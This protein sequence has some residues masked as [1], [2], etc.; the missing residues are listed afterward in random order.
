MK[1]RMR[2]PTLLILCL[3]LMMTLHLLLPLHSLLSWPLNLAGLL[4]VGAGFVLASSHA[5]LFRR[6]G[7]NIDTFGEPG[8]LVTTGCFARSRN[9]MYLGMVI[10]LGGVALLLGSL[11][12]WIGPVVFGVLV[13]W[14]YI[15]WEER[16]LAAKFG[17]DYDL[18]RRRTRRWI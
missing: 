14:V 16:M 2:P 13:Q 15:P 4:P 5:R 8:K 17:A 9:P 7:T 3:L 12:P 6:I 11:S 10:F 1:R 18:Y